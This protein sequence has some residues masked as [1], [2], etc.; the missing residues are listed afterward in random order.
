MNKWKSVLVAQSCPTLCDPMDCSLPGSSVLRIFQARILKWVAIPF[1]WGSSNP[2]IKRW[3]SALE[4]DSLPSEWS[5]NFHWLVTVQ[6][7]A[8][9]ARGGRWDRI[10]RHTEIVKFLQSENITTKHLHIYL[11]IGFSLKHGKHVVSF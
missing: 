7:E 8:G 11:F 2:G 1:S 6:G 9:G 5:A 10:Q 4:A 3:S